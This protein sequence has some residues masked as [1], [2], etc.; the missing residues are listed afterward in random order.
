MGLDRASIDGLATYLRTLRTLTR[1]PPK[2]LLVV[3][4]HWEAAVPTVTTSAA[5]P[6]IYDYYDFPPE[7]YAITWPAPGD[8]A[9]AA[10]VRTLLEGAAFSTAGDP[11]RGFDHGTFI[12]LKVTYPDAEIPTVQLSILSSLDP[13]E[14]I[15]LGRALAPLRDE[16][17]VILCSGLSFH[18]LRLFRSPKAHGIASAFDAWL[19]AASTLPAAERD[20]AFTGW[21]NAPAAREAHPREEHLLPLMVAAGAAGEDLGSIAYNGPFMGVPITA[22]HFGQRTR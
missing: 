4:A 13:A 17:I 8:P 11:G 10:R 22:V 18:N 16:G 3:S 20:R 6:I 21:S 14:H 9:L 1:E 2:G 5:P 12:P 19:R 7:S 15:R